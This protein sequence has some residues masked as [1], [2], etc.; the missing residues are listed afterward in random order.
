MRSTTS[1]GLALTL[2][3]GI[4]SCVIDTEDPQGRST[5]VPSA[6]AGAARASEP[7]ASE[8]RESSFTL[9]HANQPLVVDREGRPLEAEEASVTNPAPS[10]DALVGPGIPIKSCPAKTGKFAVLTFDDGPSPFTDELLGHL[11]AKGAP[12]AFFLKGKKLADDFTGHAEHRA[13][14]Q[15]IA[16]A[17]HEICNHT[18]THDGLVYPGK[19]EAAIRADML[20]AEDLIADVTG[21]RTR[22]MRPPYGDHNP[23]VLGILAS[24]DYRVIMWS[25]NTDDWRYGSIE[26]PADISP[27][28]ILELVDKTL[29]QST[30]PLIHIQHDAEDSEPSVATVPQVIDAIRAQGWTL[31]SLSECLGEPIDVPAQ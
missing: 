7:P 27:T 29:R 5:E 17:G 12:A 3:L 11:H 14:V 18:F 8:P 1:A 25:L 16:A 4:W 22:C 26:Y 6:G 20:D 30:E 31:I 24:L 19:G 9:E 21:R 28:K 23:Q 10:P 2:S 13:R 15:R